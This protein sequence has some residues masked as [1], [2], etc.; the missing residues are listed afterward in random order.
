MKKLVWLYIALIAIIFLF[1]LIIFSKLTIHLNY[2]HH[3]DNDDLKVEFRIWFGLIK[4]KINI[5][6]VK[7]DDN[8]PSVVVKGNSGMGNP[9]ENDSPTKVD[10]IKKDD[11]MTYL[12]NTKEILQHV[13]NMNVILRKFIK[14]I[15]IKHFEW[16]S[17]VGLG[18]AAHTGILTG[19]LW[20]IKGSF[21]GMLS[22]FLRLKK[23]PVLSVT[24]HFQLAIIQT[25]IT[26]IFQFRIG[27]AILAGLKLIKFW[28]GGRPNLKMNTANSKEKTNTV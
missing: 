2:F 27:Y 15:V 8:S 6:L 9:S 14:R 7:I 3:N 13:I 22:H 16:H 24:P 12:R 28:K 21:I 17:L 25:R 11:I 26:C 10:Q 20:T 4:Y 18:D 5:P 23:M 19:A 1:L